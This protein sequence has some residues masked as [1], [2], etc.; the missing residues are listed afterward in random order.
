MAS[1]RRVGLPYPNV[2][3][4]PALGSRTIRWVLPGCLSSVAPIELET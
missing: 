3:P 1:S 4:S 2:W